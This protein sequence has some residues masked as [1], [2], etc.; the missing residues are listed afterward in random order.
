MEATCLL[1]EWFPTATE[2]LWIFVR[3]AV[4]ELDECSPWDTHV[5]IAVVSN[6]L[7]SVLDPLCAT[8]FELQ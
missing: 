1:C 5:A 2:L 8:Q 7:T 6:L 3:F 4:A